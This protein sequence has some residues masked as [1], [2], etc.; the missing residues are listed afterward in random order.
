MP[1]QTDRP[2]ITFDVHDVLP[3]AKALGTEPTHRAVMRFFEKPVES[4]S[5]YTGACVWGVTYH[6]LFWS[7]HAAFNE[8]RPLVLSPDMIWLTVVQGL[9][10]HVRN[11]RDELW[12]HFAGAD[13]APTLSVV[14]DDFVKGSPENLWADIVKELADQVGAYLPEVREQLVPLFSTTG[15]HERMAFELALLEV[16]LPFYLYEVMAICG[17]P[18][19]TL[20][21]TT[22]DWRMLRERVDYL[23]RFDVDWWIDKLVP[24]C[25]GFIT[26]S[27][28]KRDIQHWRQIYTKD[29]AC[30]GTEFDG[31]IGHLV[32]Y[33]RGELSNQFDKRNPLLTDQG[34]KIKLA[35]LPTP[36]SR[37]PFTLARRDGVVRDHSMEF[38]SGLVAVEQ[39]DD[40]ALRPKIGWAVRELTPMEQIGA[41]G[42]LRP[43][44]GEQEMLV[45]N[46]RLSGLP[47][48]PHA[49]KKFYSECNGGVLG[50]D[51]TY[52]FFSVEV[53]EGI[54]CNVPAELVRGEYTVDSHVVPF[55][56]FGDNRMAA[57]ILG[58]GYEHHGGIVILPADGMWGQELPMVAERFEEF[59]GNAL[60]S[61]DTPFMDRPGFEAAMIEVWR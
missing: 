10:Q 3:A 52:E 57:L 6:P 17:I 28:G 19:I 43:P 8:H 2:G 11:H 27:E 47:R 61:P 38:L 22:D 9:A 59:L 14:R 48:P 13:E 21:G 24:V 35:A 41:H 46:R 54:P 37:V 32:P 56:R 55:C 60:A 5:D 20:E 1:V 7:I 39:G 16:V 26:A 15:P 36:L 18:R 31:W 30:G 49:L 4:C 50:E 44:L 25:D 40:L 42:N 53:L 51:S 45:Q 33:I 29:P 23:R 12:H 34:A 58:M